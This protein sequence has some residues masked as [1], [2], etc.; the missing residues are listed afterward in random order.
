MERMGVKEFLAEWR[1]EIETA[2]VAT[3]IDKN[4]PAAVAYTTLT[5]M[6]AKHAKQ[7]GCRVV[8]SLYTR[9][10]LVGAMGKLNNKQ[11]G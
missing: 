10:V 9:V 2:N 11:N 1:R 4:D 6:I 3:T 8:D 5:N 7:T